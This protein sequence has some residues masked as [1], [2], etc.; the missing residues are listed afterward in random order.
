MVP[1]TPCFRKKMPSDREATAKARTPSP[2]KPPGRRDRTVAVA[3]RLHHRH[4]PAL[5]GKGALQGPGVAGQG[6]QVHLRPG[7]AFGIGP[8]GPQ[9]VQCQRHPHGKGQHGAEVAQAVLYK[10]AL[11][12]RRLKRRPAPARW[13]RVRR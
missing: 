6:L 3:V 2:P 8:D 10:N 5:R 13:T 12:A 1:R 7:P 9:S 4:E 11:Q